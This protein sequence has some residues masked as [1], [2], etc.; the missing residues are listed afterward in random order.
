M[1]RLRVFLTHP[2]EALEKY[3]GPRA[4]SAL[5]D[6]VDLR[7]NP[8]G[9]V[10]DAD[11][12]AEHAAGCEIVVSDRQTPGPAAFFEQAPDLVA[13]LR[14]AVDIR[15]IDVEAAS[16][17]GILVARATPGFAT[18]VAELALGF[19]IDLARG[20]SDSVTTYRAGGT[21]VPR[22]GRQLQGATVGIIG[23]GEVGRRLSEMAAAL[24]MTVLVNDPYKSVDRAGLHQVSFDALLT[25]SDFVVCLAV[26]T[27]DTE[28]LMNAAA[29]SSMRPDAFFINLSRGNLVDEDALASALD[30]RQIAGAAMD[31]GRAPD[32]MPA[33]HLARRPN[34]LATPHVAGL[35]P[36]AIEHQAFDTVE[37]IRSLLAG[38]MPA[39][40]VN[41]DAAHRLPQRLGGSG[42]GTP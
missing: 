23:Y 6:I 22:T 8:T 42:A 24:G 36:A 31:V 30:A 39:N 20:L 38:S 18:A 28:N 3:Y 14:C 17:Q 35:T 16:R 25:Q 9:G 7:V 2:P 41:P 5:E 15:N 13:F 10:L 1:S 4:I 33:P 34:V 29:F 26:A 11:G 19:I 21:P 40:A 37:Q 32:Q 12:L 27:E